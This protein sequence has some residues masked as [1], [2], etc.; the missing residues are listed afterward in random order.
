LFHGVPLSDD[1]D[2]W[3]EAPGIFLENDGYDWNSDLFFWGGYI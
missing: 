3:W 1:E 2:D